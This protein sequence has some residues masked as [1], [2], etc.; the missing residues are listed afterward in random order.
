MADSRMPP[1]Q[2]SLVPPVVE[3]GVRALLLH[4][5]KY[6][7]WSASGEIAFDGFLSLVPL[8]A[9]LGWGL[10]H[11]RR[12]SDT[13]LEPY[14]AL[15]PLA[16]RNLIET[17]IFRLSDEG[18]QILAPLALIGFVWSASSG[19]ASAMY[20]LRRLSGAQ[21]LAWLKLRGWG[22]LWVAATLLGAIAL[23]AIGWLLSNL[24][25]L[26]LV[27]VP[28]VAVIAMTGSVWAFLRV[29][30]GRQKRLMRGTLT[31]V[32]LWIVLSTALSLSVSGLGRFALYYG[33]LA[34]VVVILLWMR[35]MAWSL[36]LGGEAA[37]AP[38]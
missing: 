19:A 23:T 24:G 37:S 22:L 28:A 26:A 6:G 13:A 1:I 10:D 25:A 38:G 21:S 18:I 3:R 27:A 4:M 33:S 20:T 12:V 32:A 9:L 7:A 36:L 31:T 14:L 17:E 2:R 34:T 29:S 35:L 15:A 11:F 8:L 16:V 5:E 30:L